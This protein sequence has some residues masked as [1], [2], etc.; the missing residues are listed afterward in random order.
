MR[1]TRE[2][3]AEIDVLSKLEGTGVKDKKIR[4]LALKIKNINIAY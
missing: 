4:E 1:W 3:T 2:E